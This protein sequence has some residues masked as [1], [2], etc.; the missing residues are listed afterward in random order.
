[1]APVAMDITWVVCVIS[2]V[3]VVTGSPEN[4][5]EFS[6]E[7]VQDAIGNT[8]NA[9]SQ[10]TWADMP[11]DPDY[12]TDASPVNNGALETIFVLSNH[13]INTVQP[14]DV[15]QEHLSDKILAHTLMWQHDMENAIVPA[16]T[17]G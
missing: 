11:P 13:F 17:V 7:A 15:P 5:A 9:D 4:P 2:C 14:N 16:V 12:A 8:A 10:I 1:M 6:P 3:V